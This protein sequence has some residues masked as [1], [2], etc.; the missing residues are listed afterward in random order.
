MAEFSI[1]HSQYYFCYSEHVYIY[2]VNLRIY[3]QGVY[4]VKSNF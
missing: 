1:S 4:S 3:A 2:T